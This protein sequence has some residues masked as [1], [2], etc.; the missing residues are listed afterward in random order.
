[1]VEAYRR[2]GLPDNAIRNLLAKNALE[3][4]WGKSAQG[5]YNFGNIITGKYWNGKY[6]KGK[7]YDGNGNIITNYFRA[8]NSLNDYVRDELQFLT[9]L[10]DFDP[11]DDIDIFI[12]KLQGGNKG[13]RSY[14][15]SKSYKNA[16]KNVYRNV[17]I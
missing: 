5:A 1:M 3:S 12:H 9:R 17:K 11:N 16:L 15:E 10:Y 14:A 7:D 2:E 8:Y 4:G 13:G 6:A